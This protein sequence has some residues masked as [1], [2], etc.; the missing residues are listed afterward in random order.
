MVSYFC[1]CQSYLPLRSGSCQS[2]A[3][4]D[5]QAFG[6]R[7]G[8][9]Q[10]APEASAWLWPLVEPAEVGE[11]VPVLQHTRREPRL[12]LLASCLTTILF[13]PKSVS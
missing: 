11:P 1:Y 12:G 10:A 5:L 2:P 4:A 13:T 3:A 7:L 8:A 6:L 9:W